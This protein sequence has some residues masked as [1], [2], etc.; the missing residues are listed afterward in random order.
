MTSMQSMFQSPSGVKLQQDRPKTCMRSRKRIA[1]WLQ[2][3]RM[4][5]QVGIRPWTTAGRRGLQQRGGEYTCAALLPRRPSSG[6]REGQA[7]D[8][9]SVLCC[10]AT[11]SSI[12]VAA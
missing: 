8:A 9:C 5:Q 4:P 1:M 2:E 7:H 3:V 12:R 10:C 11:S 6:T